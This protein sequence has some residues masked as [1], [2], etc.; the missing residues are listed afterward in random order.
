MTHPDPD[1]EAELAAIR[2]RML[3][4]I[5][6]EQVLAQALWQAVEIDGPPQWQVADWLALAR[7]IIK[8]VEVA[9]DISAEELAKAMNS[10]PRVPLPTLDELE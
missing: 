4:P 2:E 8:V 10:P 3:K 1:P 5:S 7:H 9:G 6:R